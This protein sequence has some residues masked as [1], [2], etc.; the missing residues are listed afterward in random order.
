M[1][2][3]LIVIDVQESFRHRPY[4]TERDLPAY[5][6]A[7]NALIEGCA[8]RGV[9]IVRIF[10]V[11]GPKTQA[12]SFAVE[13]G[14]VCALTDLTAFDAAATFHK[15]RHSA[16]VGTGLD[17]WLAQN[18]IQKIIISGIRT[19]QC[20]ETT[21]RHASDMGYSVDYVTDATLTF[22][23]QLADGSPLLAADIKAR[24]A[25]VLKDRFARVCS[26]Q[27]AIESAV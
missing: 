2:T 19:E 6:A 17:V 5:L 20:C 24:T 11:E 26:V 16:L 13:S 15:N 4:F 25:A 27:E 7:Q 18:G 8:A 14:H 21:T 23:M 22:E 12:N 9:P 1:K 10:H 3:C